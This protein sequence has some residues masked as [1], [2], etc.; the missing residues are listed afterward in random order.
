MNGKLSYCSDGRSSLTFVTISQ[1]FEPPPTGEMFL[2]SAASPK[3]RLVSTERVWSPLERAAF[4]HGVNG[5][6]SNMRFR[7]GRPL[8][9]GPPP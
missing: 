7:N 6:A 2:F 3:V 4:G 5:E 9:T 8:P 1:I